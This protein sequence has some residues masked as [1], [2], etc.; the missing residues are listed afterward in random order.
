MNSQGN[1]GSTVSDSTMLIEMKLD[2]QLKTLLR[3]RDITVA[4]LARK[5]GVS[6]KTIYNW[7][8]RQRPRDIDAV[9]KVAD[10]FNVTLDFLF[11][12]TPPPMPSNEFERHLEEV[13][14]GL[15]E[16]VLRRPKAK[17]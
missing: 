6:P 16:V 3:E 8:E 10:H 9:K 7:L 4:Q 17:E 14:A 5:A 13:N 2:K 11:Y 15:F 12:G 1:S